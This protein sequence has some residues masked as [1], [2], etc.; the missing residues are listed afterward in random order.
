MDMTQDVRDTGQPHDDDTFSGVDEGG[1]R[2]EHTPY[3]GGYDRQP[4]DEMVAI[5]AARG[6]A[7]APGA[8]PNSDADTLIDDPHASR[9]NRA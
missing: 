4:A 2:G 1:L 3:A 7:D 8:G 5:D 9:D 6:H